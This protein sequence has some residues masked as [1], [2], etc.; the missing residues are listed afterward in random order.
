MR[1]E[2]V[3]LRGIGAR[4]KLLTLPYQLVRSHQQLLLSFFLH[5]KNYQIIR[6]GLS[7]KIEEQRYGHMRIAANVF[8]SPNAKLFECQ[9]IFYRIAIILYL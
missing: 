9:L 8:L 3:R 1:Q 5:L 4:L 7:A 2:L 6:L